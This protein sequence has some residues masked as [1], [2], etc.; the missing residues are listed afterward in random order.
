ML[1][2]KHLLFDHVIGFTQY[3]WVLKDKQLQKKTHKFY[4]ETCQK[5]SVFLDRWHLIYG[6]IFENSGLVYTHFFLTLTKSC[7]PG[8]RFKRV[9][10]CIQFNVYYRLLIRLYIHHLLS[11]LYFCS[12][13]VSFCL[14]VLVFWIPFFVK[15]VAIFFVSYQ[16]FFFYSTRNIFWLSVERK[17]VETCFYWIGCID[18]RFTKLR[19]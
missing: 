12:F 14:E 8:I 13:L 19:Y 15:W 10:L 9:W 6:I 17:W 5:C 4:L 3:F 2:P 1:K 18:K 16:G 11:L 7:L